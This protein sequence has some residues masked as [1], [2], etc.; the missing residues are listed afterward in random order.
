MLGM[1]KDINKD[2]FKD[3]AES[4]FF[5]L[6]FW[7]PWCRPCLEFLPTFKSASEFFAS[8]SDLPKVEFGKVNIDENTDIAANYGVRS[9]PTLIVFK[10]GVEIGRFIGGM[11]ENTFISKIIEAIKQ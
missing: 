4:G 11:D 8:K 9:I 7:A 2:N 1:V 3:I 6:D 5:I 10:K